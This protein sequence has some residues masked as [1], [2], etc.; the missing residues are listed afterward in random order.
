ME[1]VGIYR[2]EAPIFAVFAVQPENPVEF[3]L[4]KRNSWLTAFLQS[5]ALVL[6][7]QFVLHLSRQVALYFRRRA[8]NSL[9]RCLWWVEHR[10]KIAKNVSL[11]PDIFLYQ[12]ACWSRLNMIEDLERLPV[13]WER[14]KML[15]C[16]SIL[17]LEILLNHSCNSCN[18]P[19]LATP[20][21]VK[22]V[23]VSY[24]DFLSIFD[25]RICQL[26]IPELFSI[27]HFMNTS[28]LSFSKCFL[29]HDQF[30]LWSKLLSARF[31]RSEMDIL[32]F[33]TLRMSLPLKFTKAS[34]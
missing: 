2:T 1:G 34:V 19:S 7:A 23:A 32:Q 28:D 29:F 5:S 9:I 31:F 13:D 20:V 22:W 26:A 14:E 10:T 21:F 30:F 24:H 3:P 12:V 33:Q 18:S 27:F 25:H 8:K 15:H 17:F 4:A 6:C 11:C 16:N